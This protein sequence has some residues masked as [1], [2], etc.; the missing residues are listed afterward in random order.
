MGVSVCDIACGM[1]AH[2]AVLE[3]LAIRTRLAVRRIVDR[4]ADAAAADEVAAGQLRRLGRR[5]ERDSDAQVRRGSNGGTRAGASQATGRRAC[6][7]QGR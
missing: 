1:T 4:I 3:A 2:Q 6:E 5:W 7:E